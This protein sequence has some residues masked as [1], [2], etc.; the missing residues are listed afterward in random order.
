M[1][2]MKQ[3]NIKERTGANERGKKTRETIYVH[4]SSHMLWSSFLQLKRHSGHIT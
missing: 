2:E 1:R 3:A 4:V